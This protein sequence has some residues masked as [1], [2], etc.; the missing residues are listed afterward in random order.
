MRGNLY[1]KKRTL[2]KA[3]RLSSSNIIV[4]ALRIYYLLQLDFNADFTYDGNPT[5]IW[6]VIEPCMAVISACVPLFRP[7]LE[8]IFPRLRSRPAES[9]RYSTFSSQK[10]RNTMARD[11][12]ET[13]SDDNIPLQDASPHR[14]GLSVVPTT[15]PAGKGEDWDSDYRGLSASA[16]VRRM[17][18]NSDRL[19]TNAEDQIW[20][21]QDITLQYGESAKR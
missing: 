16:E 11:Q 3:D 20:V 13:V 17:T 14:P 1:K 12:Y 19:N 4:A 8:R 9:S 15:V 5:Y 18:P 21:R 2:K 6:S 10:K 7:L